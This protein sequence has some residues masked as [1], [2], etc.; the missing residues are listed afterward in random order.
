ME[1][2]EVT[3][4]VIGGAIEV[5]RAMGP[6]LEY[7]L[8]ERGLKCERQKRLPVE[9]RGIHRFVHQLPE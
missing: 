5:H 9:Y 3:K 2:N 4:A 1:W 8:L 6:G 7:E